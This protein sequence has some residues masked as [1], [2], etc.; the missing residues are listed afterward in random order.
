MRNPAASS[1]VQSARLSSF[2][3]GILSRRASRTL[4]SY[5]R[6][7]DHVVDAKKPRNLVGMRAL[8]Q[9]RFASARWIFERRTFTHCHSLWVSLETAVIAQFGDTSK[10]NAV[11]SSQQNAC[12]MKST[13]SSTSVARRGMSKVEQQSP[14]RIIEDVAVLARSH[15]HQ[16]LRL[17]SERMGGAQ[18]A[19]A[20]VVFSPVGRRPTLKQDV[21]RRGAPRCACSLS[22]RQEQ[23]SYLQRGVFSRGALPGSAVDL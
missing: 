12:M 2:H 23:M 5:L 13:L 11:S 22:S 14:H 10:P 19:K 17:A 21:R 18:G 7:L 8:L 9:G 20:R 3:P 6:S 15:S 1:G 4:R 16:F